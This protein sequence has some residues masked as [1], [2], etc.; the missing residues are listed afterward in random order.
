VK[1]SGLT[2]Y[3]IFSV[4]Q[5]SGLLYR[6]NIMY[7]QHLLCVPK[8][9]GRIC[10]KLLRSVF[11]SAKPT[12]STAYMGATLELQRSQRIEQ[13]ERQLAWTQ[14]NQRPGVIVFCA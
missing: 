6:N 14:L 2:E 4:F 1:L 8:F 13:L 3:F 5:L 10:D 12:E 11:Y 7:V 9:I